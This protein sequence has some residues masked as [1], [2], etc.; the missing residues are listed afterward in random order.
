MPTGFLGECLRD[1]WYKRRHVDK[2]SSL[3]GCAVLCNGVKTSMR[4]QGLYSKNC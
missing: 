4:L 3:S 2:Y 1:A